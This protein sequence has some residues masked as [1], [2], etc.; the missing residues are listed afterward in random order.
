MAT[1]YIPEIL[2]E[3][4]SKPETIKNFG[5]IQALKVILYH[6]FVPKYK[7]KLPDGEPPFKV[8]SE[9]LGLTPANLLTEHKKL[10][11]LVRDDIKQTKR[12]SI[13]IDLLETIHESETK[14]IFAVKD[15][16]LHKLYTNITEQ[17]VID[18]GLIP[19]SEFK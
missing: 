7:F 8:S 1:K 5:N 14:I 16:I 15:Q 19:E 2:E 6:A 9:P 18:S 17:L 11:Y 12:E 4:N 13:F 3:I 10:V